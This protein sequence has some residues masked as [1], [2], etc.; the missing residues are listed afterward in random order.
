MLSVPHRRSTTVA[1][2]IYPLYILD[3]KLSNSSL[4]R[5]INSLSYTLLPCV[6]TGQLLIAR[7]WLQ[8][9]IAIPNLHCAIRKRIQLSTHY[10]ITKHIAF[11]T[12]RRKFEVVF[13]RRTRNLLSLSWRAVSVMFS[14]KANKSKK[15][16]FRWNLH[17]ISPRN[18][19]LR[20]KVGLLAY[21]TLFV[22][23][24][25]FPSRSRSDK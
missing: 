7:N 12:L 13:C 25:N 24:C 1:L 23:L 22:K 11:I 16:N 19:V 8:F 5:Q 3:V 2:E 18:Q 21:I 14:L 15:M 17:Q 9:N 10:T 20:E 4:N 6:I